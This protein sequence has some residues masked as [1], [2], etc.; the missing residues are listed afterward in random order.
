MLTVYLGLRFIGW[1]FFNVPESKLAVMSGFCPGLCITFSALKQLMK[2]CKLVF[3]AT[4]ILFFSCNQ[5]QQ[6][7]DMSADTIRA[8]KVVAPQ[9][10]AA[11][12]SKLIGSW[13][14]TDAP[15]EIRIMEM[16][17]GG[18]MLAG[19]FNPKSINVGRANWANVN[20]ALNVY[21]ELRDEN[22]PGS[23]YVLQYLP[24]QDVLAGKYFQAVE[25][26]TYDVG[27]T[28]KK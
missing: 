11:D 6:N 15:Y 14:R 25:G 28:R 10:V 2:P 5:T 22:Y 4:V 12:S 17:S 3:L 16:S 7:Q 13:T 21:I 24:E 26:V 8:D 20:G 1:S 19:Y 23:N 27:F 9:F 18:N